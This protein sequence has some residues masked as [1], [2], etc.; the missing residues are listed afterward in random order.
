MTVTFAAGTSTV[1][2]LAGVPP[3]SSTKLTVEPVTKPVPVIVT[4][5]PPVIGPVA[6][7]MPVTVGTVGDQT[8]LS[9]TMLVPQYTW[10]G[11]DDGGARPCGG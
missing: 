7:L 3:D 6:G 10:H 8:Q 1:L 2:S 11:A 5:V 9:V 4:G